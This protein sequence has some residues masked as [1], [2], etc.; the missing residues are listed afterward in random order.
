MKEP[1]RDIPRGTVGG[2]AI[3]MVI[4]VG[5]DHTF[6]RMINELDL[7]AGHGICVIDSES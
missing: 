2:I 6:L 3:V 1:E 4:H 7:C 5:L